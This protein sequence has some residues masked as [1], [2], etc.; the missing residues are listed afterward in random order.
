MTE[1]TLPQNLKLPYNNEISTDKTSLFHLK[2][3]TIFTQYS[4]SVKKIS[5]D[6][7]LYIYIHIVQKYTSL[8]ELNLPRRSFISLREGY[9]NLY[10][11]EN[12]ASR[13]NMEWQRSELS[14]IVRKFSNAAQFWSLP[15][16]AFH[17]CWY[18]SQ[19]NR[20]ESSLTDFKRVCIHATSSNFIIF[21]CL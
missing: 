4:K 20:V 8:L 18:L 14:S 15:F 10:I 7:V 5:I 16:H 13:T 21:S 2:K 1:L 3:K 9:D 12:R 17:S 19:E 11:F 6:S